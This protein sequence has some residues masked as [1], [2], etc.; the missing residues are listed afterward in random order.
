MR[1]A[2][3]HPAQP[4]LAAAVAQLAA[5][6]QAGADEPQLASGAAAEAELLRRA[7]M[8]GRG[9]GGADGRAACPGANLAWCVRESASGDCR[10]LGARA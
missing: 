4:F 8:V 3:S 1:A 7:A 9:G 5:Q 10:A 6:Q 2:L